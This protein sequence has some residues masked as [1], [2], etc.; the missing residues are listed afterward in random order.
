[1]NNEIYCTNTN[2]DKKCKFNL[3]YI[4]QNINFEKVLKGDLSK[5]CGENKREIS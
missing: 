1:M 5:Y 2:C 4:I 3:N